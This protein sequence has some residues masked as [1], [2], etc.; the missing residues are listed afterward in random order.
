MNTHFF[1]IVWLSLAMAF[2]MM[3][4]TPFVT[5]ASDVSQCSYYATIRITNNGTSAYNV[6]VPLTLNTSYFVDNGYMSSS[7]NNTAMVNN[8]GNDTAYNPAILS[9]TTWMIFVPVI[10]ANSSIDYAL[11]MGGNQDAD[12]KLSLIP[13]IVTGLSSVD[14]ASL[15]LAN[16]FSISQTGF[17][18]TSYAVGKNLTAKAGAIVCNVTANGNVTASITGI[19]SLTATD[20]ATGEH[21]INL[22]SNGSIIGL[23][24]DYDPIT[25]NASDINLD[26]VVNQLDVDLVQHFILFPWHPGSLDDEGEY[27][28]SDVDLSG[29]ITVGDITRVSNNYTRLMYDLNVDGILNQLDVTALQNYILLGTPFSFKW[30]GDYNESGTV[31]NADVTILERH[32]YPTLTTTRS[33]QNITQSSS[34]SGANAYLYSGSY[35]RVAQYMPF[36][37]GTI[38][39]VGFYLKSFGSPTGNVSCII[40]DADDNILKTMGEIDASALT[41]NYTWVQFNDFSFYNPV[42][43]YLSFDIE[44]NDGDSSN[45]IAVGFTASDL[46]DGYRRLYNTRW[47]GEYSSDMLY[48][49]NYYSPTSVSDTSTDWQFAQN[50]TYNYLTTQTIA[51]NGTTV[52]DISWQNLAIWIDA[53]GYGNNATPTFRTTTTNPNVTAYLMDIRT[54]HEA[55]LSDWDLSSYTNNL[56]IPDMPGGMYDDG[57]P[58]FPGHA[59]FDDASTASNLPTQL[60][61]FIVPCCLLVFIG[62]IVHDKTKS[63]VAQ[64]LIIMIVT[65]FISLT[66]VWAFWVIIPMALIGGASTLAGKVYGY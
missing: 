10:P 54:F 27:L 9:N 43:R 15:E 38:T 21:T 61:W 8:Y 25:V 16:N 55:V 14:S 59:I 37:A 63:L 20:V 26:G 57:S 28:R 51:V 31:T 53:S 50:S 49:I 33:A 45:K 40:R 42:Y 13:G 58:T 23:R 30:A 41:S 6:S 48:Q 7:L 29:N 11:Y 46:S 4:V 65:I 60:F 66:H 64:F 5:L 17:I 24:V 3:L 18:D 56:D 47:F 1:K 2:T 32:I 12:G 62:L 35:I 34:L 36:P 52:Q 44:Y 39:N 22:F 19:G